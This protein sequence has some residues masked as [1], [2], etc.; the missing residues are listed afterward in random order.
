[1]EKLTLTDVRNLIISII[2][3]QAS[4]LIGTIFTADAIPTWYATLN[5]PV[6]TPPNWLFGPVWTTLYTLMGISAF[7]VWRR[8]LDEQKVRIGMIF[9]AIQLLLNGLWTPIFFGLKELF[10][11]LIIIIILWITILLTI[12]SFSR[13]S[14]TPGI[15]LMPYIAWVSLATALNYAIFVLNP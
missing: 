5:K 3:C 11:A 13:I 8:G 2:I 9:F 4:G 10:A 1:M 14:L 12:I 7:L 6:F 15:L